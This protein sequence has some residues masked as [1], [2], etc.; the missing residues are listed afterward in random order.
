MATHH[1]VALLIPSWGHVGSYIY[2]ATQ[3]LQR[4]PTLV[5]TMVEHNSMVPQMEAE[6]LSC[7]YDTARLRIIGVGDK[8]MTPGP[9]MIKNAFRQLGGGWIEHIGKLAQSSGGWPK[10]QAVHID[11]LGGGLAIDPIK[12]M[13]GSDCKIL[14][15][16]S[17]GLV[18]MPGTFND[19]DFAAIA[20]EIYVDE[21]RRAGRSLDDILKAVV[22][23]RNGSDKLSGRI[24]KYP[25]I[26]DMYDYESVTDSANGAPDGIAPIVVACRK[27]GQVANGYI[28]PTATCLEPVGV[29]Q[30]RAL[31]QK[32]GQELF[33]VGLQVHALAW[34]DTA[35]AAPTNELVNSFLEKALTQHGPKSVLYISFGSFFFPVSQ[36]QHLEAL[37]T[38]LLDLEKPF[39]F[40]FSLGGKMASL[41]QE[42][43]ERVNTSGK[44]LICDFWVEQRAILQHEGVGWFL[45]HGG[46]NSVCESLSQGVPLIMWPTNAEQPLNAALLSSSPDPVAIELL[47]IR[48]G[49]QVRPSLIWGPAITGA[50]ADA[51]AEF[52]AVFADARGERGAVLTTNAIRMAKALREARAGEAAAELVR[53]AAF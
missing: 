52:K 33:T 46:Y 6:L 10:P 13:V 39:P 4:D 12:K 1:I 47:Q 53:L 34:S 15:W 2:L 22:G 41:P 38:T 37:V 36:P 21:A 5:I 7:E 45:S 27:L 8:E 23:A 18:S 24:V 17:S 40:I 50:V 31:Y 9:D 14:V 11:Y 29:P 3:M 26:P 20:Q 28:V 44:G 25:G 19:Y 30:C 16:Y 51:A 35:P 42:L 48:A 43:I 32:L 49:S